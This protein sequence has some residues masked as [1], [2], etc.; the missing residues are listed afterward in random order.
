MIQF[1]NSFE[2]VP[3]FLEAKLILIDDSLQSARAVVDRIE[4]A[5][6]A[7]MSMITGMVCGMLSVIC[8]GYNLVPLSLSINPSRR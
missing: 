8:R 5:L 4:I 1:V 7:P 3:D 6:D 2:A